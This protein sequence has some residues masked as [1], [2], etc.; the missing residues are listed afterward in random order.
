M[1]R[2]RRRT[3]QQVAQE[4]QDAF[5]QRILDIYAGA[6]GGAMEP[7]F[8]VDAEQLSRIIPAVQ[9]TFGDVRSIRYVYSAHSLGRWETPG[10]LAEFLFNVGFRA[11]EKWIEEKEDE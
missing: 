7:G 3:A 1:P 4:K 10:G 9:E 8:C 5:L 6:T 11:D 2:R